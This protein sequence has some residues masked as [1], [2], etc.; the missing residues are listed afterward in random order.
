MP[1]FEYSA[2]D[3]RGKSTTGVIDADSA[4][5]ARQKLRGKDIFPVSI[6]ELRELAVTPGKRSFA[7]LGDIFTRVNPGELAMM[8]RQLATLLGAGFPL[9]GAL[10]TLIPQIPRRGLKK[11]LTQIKTAVVEGSSLAAALSQF[12][13]IFSPLYINMVRAGESSGTLEIVLE[14]LADTMEKQQALKSRITAAMAYPVLMAILGSAILVGL[15][16]FI[17][18]NITSLF[19]DMGKALPTPTRVLIALSSGLRSYWWIGAAGLVVGFLLFYRLRRTPKG[20]Y[21]IDRTLLGLPGL[22]NLIRKIAVS[23]FAHTLASLLEN[24]V[25]MLSALEIVKNIA[26]NQ[27]FSSIIENAAVEVGRGQGLGV[28]LAEGNAFP[29][30]ATQMIQVGE[31]SG[32]LESMLN[33]MAD[34]YEREVENKIMALTALLEPIMILIMG[35]AV[36]FIVLSICLPIFEMNQL[37]L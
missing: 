5:A 25:P 21:F 33:K 11:T 15:M 24:G 37:V 32:E 13:R 3:R 2:L 23:R 12:S 9:V 34:V 35:T 29:L 30:L 7:F 16:M 22:R 20:H 19:T 14:R 18:P 36:L 6:K 26:G 4:A 27:V 1:V 31:Q 8:T 17:V 10:D 28:S